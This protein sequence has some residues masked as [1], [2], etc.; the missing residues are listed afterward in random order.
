LIERRAQGDAIMSKAGDD[1]PGARVPLVDPDSDE[2]VV[3][4]IF[5]NV[6]A[7]RAKPLNMH[8][9]MANAPEP[10]KAR[11]NYAM[12]LRSKTAIARAH[13]EL[14]ILRV[15]HL[16]NGDYVRAEH[17][18]MAMASGLSAEQIDAVG[19][20]RQSAAFDDVQQAVLAYT[21]AMMA[22]ESVD[23]ATFDALARH[24]SPREI[25]ELT[26]TV[27]FYNSTVM[28]TRALRVPLEKSFGTGAVG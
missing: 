28:N 22:P 20:W 6:R 25:V 26:M 23:D 1:D 5:A 18:P 7:R 16:A 9:A 19:A 11:I 10:F 13:R 17:V 3:A 15:A 24:F 21:D 8:R 12:A 2:P 14:A 4:E 27:S